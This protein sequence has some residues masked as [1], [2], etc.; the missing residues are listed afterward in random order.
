MEETELIEQIKDH[1]E[2]AYTVFIDLHKEMI[3]RICLGF[4]NGKED[5]EHLAC[6]SDGLNN[7]RPDGRLGF[8]RNKDRVTG[9]QRVL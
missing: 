9:I 3:F 4:V 2:K 7:H 5:A 1:K 6:N 8:F